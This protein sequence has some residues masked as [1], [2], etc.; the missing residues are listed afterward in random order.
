MAYAET[1]RLATKL[2]GAT[3]GGGVGL[4]TIV[5]NRCLDGFE[6]DAART[7]AETHRA[8]VDAAF[9]RQPLAAAAKVEVPAL[10]TGSELG[11]VFGLKYFG[12]RAFEGD[13]AAAALDGIFG[14]R[15]AK[16][17]VCGG[18][19]GVG[20]TTVSS[21]LG[22]ALADRGFDTLVIST[23]PA[24]SLGDCL[25][26]DLSGGAVVEVDAPSEG[27]LF[28]LEVDADA[29]A[30]EAAALLK[31]GLGEKLRSLGDAGAAAADL[32]DALETSPPGLDELVS[33]LKVLELIRSKNYDRI[34]L[35]TAPTGHTLRLLALPELMDDFAERSMNARDRLKRNPVVAAALAGA[36][37]SGG[38]G[39]SGG[40]DAVRDV[41][42]DA[43]AMDA[44][45]H[46]E[47]SC[48]FLAV[49]APTDL[50]LTETANLLDSLDEAGIA[51]RA[52][53]VNG[54]LDGGDD[55]GLAAFS[56]A[57]ETTQAAALA[58]L[59]ALADE[60]RVDLVR[61]PQFDGDLPA[62]AA[63]LAKLGDALFR[64]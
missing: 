51:C 1:R 10:H 45:L 38:G 62:G 6:V 58:E 32:A 61:T 12:S 31:E 17:V 22:V 54:V 7:L 36:G 13:A 40:R 55:A 59:H 11:G 27:R 24:H 35:D 15:E 18:K 44:I 9:S 39:E 60:L 20:K 43:F 56:A 64:C 19:G 5:V 46:D 23:D 28:A 37:F 63:G 16:L 53:V 29:A 41:Q 50:S 48:E 47:A 30:L 8:N 42:D 52:V 34:V 25:A 26:V 57:A 49:A 2:A 21:A 3:Q 4:R 14:Q 33:L